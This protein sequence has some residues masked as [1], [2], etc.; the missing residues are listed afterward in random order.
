MINDIQKDAKIRMTKSI[1][2]FEHDLSKIRADRP[3]LIEVDGG[4]SKGNV[5]R[6]RN[7]GA[8]AFVAG[9]SVFFAAD[10]TSAV[11]ELRELMAK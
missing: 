10:R 3:F 9:A 8:D 6:L 4:I 2:G 5:Q 11:R 1:E 7:A